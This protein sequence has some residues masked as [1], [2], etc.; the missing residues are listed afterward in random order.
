MRTS[1]FEGLF[2]NYIEIPFS[3]QNM[4]TTESCVK[5]S[6]LEDRHKDIFQ[7]IEI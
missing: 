4:E 2:L 7:V 3:G 6:N 5:D 1:T